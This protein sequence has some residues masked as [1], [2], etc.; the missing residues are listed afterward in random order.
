MASALEEGAL[1][2]LFLERTEAKKN[3]WRDPE[4]Q[5]RGIRTMCRWTGKGAN[6]LE[7]VFAEADS[8]PKTTD[9]RAVWK[10]RHGRGAAPVL[11]MVGYGGRATLCG[12][13]GDEPPVVDLDRDRA[14][15]LAD[16]ALREP[17]RRIAVRRISDD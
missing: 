7:V 16:F 3:S 4:A 10:A 15:R 6:G 1:N 11:P 5:R 14:E 17:H 2:S 13:T 12:P 8:K 9:V